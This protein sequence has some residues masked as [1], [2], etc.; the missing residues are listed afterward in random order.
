[1]N[2]SGIVPLAAFL[3]KLLRLID[4]DLAIV[5][6][7]DGPAFEGTRGGA[8]EIDAADVKAAAVAGAFEFAFAFEP[9]W[10]AAEMGASGAQRVKLAFI[11]DKPDLFRLVFLVDL[12]FFEVVG[13]ADL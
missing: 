5:A 7:V 9:V 11:A 13:E 6:D 1:M 2:D 4:D 3:L 10:S 8:F 12:A